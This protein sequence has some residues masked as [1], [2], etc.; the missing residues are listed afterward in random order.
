MF[1]KASAADL[2]YVGRV[3]DRAPDSKLSYTQSSKINARSPL[4]CFYFSNMFRSVSSPKYLSSSENEVD[5][6]HF[7]I[8]VL[9]KDSLIFDNGHTNDEVP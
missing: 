6:M 7:R 5:Y 3:K 1:A 9:L 2:L 8:S 4:K